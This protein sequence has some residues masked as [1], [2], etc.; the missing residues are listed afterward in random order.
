MTR[1]DI[2]LSSTDNSHSNSDGD[3]DDLNGEDSSGD[4]EEEEDVLPVYLWKPSETTDVLGDWEV[5]TKVTTSI[6]RLF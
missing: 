2:Y 5:H 6:I 3:E 4:E 1:V